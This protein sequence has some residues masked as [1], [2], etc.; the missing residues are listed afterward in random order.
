MGRILLTVI[1]PLLLPTALYV[2]WRLSLGRTTNL[3]SMSLWLAA[4]G[5]GLAALTLVL[6]NTDF[7][8]PRQGQYV[9]PH[10]SDGVVVPGR[11]EPGAA[12][13]VPAR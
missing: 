1:I 9:P 12:E 13:P 2:G 5:I 3:T 7:S 4:A 10:V 8:G 6:L 11:I